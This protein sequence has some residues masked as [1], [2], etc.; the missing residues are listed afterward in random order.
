MSFL[1][2]PPSDIV[3]GERLRR[4]R[5]LGPAVAR[6][7]RSGFVP[8][9]SCVDAGAITRSLY[10]ELERELLLDLSIEDDQIPDAP[11]IRSMANGPCS[12]RTPTGTTWP[13]L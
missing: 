9:S 7:M 1:H 12:C 10:C 6:C 13:T 4:D 3:G 5:C 2:Y 8:I 11:R